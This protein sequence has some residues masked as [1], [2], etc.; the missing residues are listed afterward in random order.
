MQTAFNLYAA[1]CHITEKSYYH[2]IPQY[3]QVYNIAGSNCEGLNLFL[4]HQT[5]EQNIELIKTLIEDINPTYGAAQ[6]SIIKTIINGFNKDENEQVYCKI[7]T[8]LLNKLLYNV[9]LVDGDFLDLISNIVITKSWM[10]KQYTLEMMIPFLVKAISEN[11]NNDSSL[12]STILLKSL[13]IVSDFVNYQQYKLSRRTHLIN[14]FIVFCMEFILQAQLNDAEDLYK[15][16][17]RLIMNFIDPIN[18]IN[19]NSNQDSLK[20]NVLAYKQELRKYIYPIMLKYINTLCIN[21]SGS[22][23]SI[24]MVNEFRN[25]LKLSMYAIFDLLI[26]E[27]INLMYNLLDYNGK[28]YFKKLYKDYENEGKW[29]E[30]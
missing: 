29:G 8:S 18:I 16:L 25:G 30:D 10:L 6:L 1:Y 14:S 17:N 23:I 7:F 20:S 4:K 28:L 13:K 9:N 15:S 27:N 24:K 26:K 11:V 21:Y 19:S 22:R 12:Q 3:F 2:I 5:I